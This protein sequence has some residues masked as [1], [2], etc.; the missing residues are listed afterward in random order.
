MN[1]KCRICFNDFVP[2]DETM[3]QICGEFIDS[4]SVNIC[5]DCWGLIQLS[6]YDLS[7]SYSDA[8][9]AL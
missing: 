2:D 7:E 1:L 3:D 6:Q 4:N 5:D 9:Q 8:E